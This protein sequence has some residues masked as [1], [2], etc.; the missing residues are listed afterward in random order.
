MDEDALIVA[1]KDFA[2]D[3]RLTGVAATWVSA[4]EEWT[5]IQVRHAGLYDDAPDGWAVERKV[6]SL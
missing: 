6:T 1:L 5:T 3:H 2:D 4:R